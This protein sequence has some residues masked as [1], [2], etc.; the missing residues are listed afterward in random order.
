[1]IS[2]AAVF[3]GLAYV[4]YLLWFALVMWQARGAVTWL[5]GAKKAGLAPRTAPGFSPKVPQWVR[6]VFMPRGLPAPA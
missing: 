4:A 2:G 5:F 1:M 3:V 6:P